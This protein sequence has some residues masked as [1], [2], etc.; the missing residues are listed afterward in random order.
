MLTVRD[1]LALAELN[2]AE[3]VA[4]AQGLDRVVRWVHI[5]GVPD[6]AHWL[7]GGELVLT[8]AINLPEGEE[9]Q[10]A[11]VRA[12]D[13]AGVAGLVLTVGK[14]LQRVPDHLREVAEA[15]G[16]PLM[17]LPFTAHF[18]D[19]AKSVN[20]RIAET[21]MAMVQRALDIHKVL[22][23]VVLEGGGLKELARRLAELVGH[24]IS[25]ENAQFEA[26]VTVNL[27][28]TDEA[29]RYTQAHKRTDPRLVAALEDRG[30]LPQI[31][32]ELRPQQL[33]P[34][35]DVGLEMERILAPVVVH[36]AIY[37]YL[38]IIAD[39]H[40]LSEIDRMAIESGSTIAAL[41]M[42]YQ[43]SIQNA[44][45]SL[46]GSLLARLI[47]GEPV[48][49][50]ILHDQSLRYGVDLRAPFVVAILAPASQPL[51]PARLYRGA[52][53]LVND[54]AWPAV[55]GQ[56]AGE[57]VM[58][59]QAPDATQAPEQQ[60]VKALRSAS[61]DEALHAAFS[62][63]LRG[64][65]QVPAAYRQARDVLAI[66]GRLG[67]SAPAVAFGELGY[68]HTLY[69]AGPASLQTNPDVAILRRFDDEKHPDLL[70]TLEA[71]LDAGGNGVRAAERLH[72]HRSTLNYRLVRIHAIIGS[73]LADAQTRTN[74]LVALKLMRLFGTQAP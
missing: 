49:D 36:G 58:L 25:I 6:V 3:V 42:L 66:C 38:W 50:T 64:P 24:S 16:L 51:T 28:V 44:E 5:G 7:R 70:L 41:I 46:K 9:A 26:I 32:R 65:E 39:H 22:T 37:G 1:T 73:D 17:E 4:G 31:R 55:V 12:L 48:R 34:M 63:P 62:A 21:N 47:S 19:I 69:A 23:G 57:T 29:R 61:G 35:P 68:V 72:I 10:V 18:V 33:P 11:Y 15:L 74:L 59:L 71:Y 53:Q 8:T 13:A 14:Y 43:E 52:N 60:L 27:G 54:R 30:I 40:S 20:E 56:F 67:W 2:Q 45:A